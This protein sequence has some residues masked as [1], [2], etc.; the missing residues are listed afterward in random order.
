MN[1]HRPVKREISEKNFNVGTH[2]ATISKIKATKSRKGA[3][4]FMMFLMGKNGEKGVYFLTFG[5]DFTQNNLNFILASIEDNG[6]DIPDMMFGY[7]PHTTDFMVGKNV[8]I[9]VE[10]QFYNGE[11]KPSVTVFLSQHEFENSAEEE[12]VE[13]GE[14]ETSN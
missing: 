1:Y 2:A 5:N 8:Y 9:S 4:M 10:D 12:V 11:T 6:V 3:D 7:N 14:W 13:A